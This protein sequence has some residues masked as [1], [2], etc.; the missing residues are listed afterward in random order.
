MICKY[1]DNKFHQDPRRTVLHN[2]VLNNC[3]INMYNKPTIV[4][5][6]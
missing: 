6:L 1:K 5:D 2:P 4:S 3:N